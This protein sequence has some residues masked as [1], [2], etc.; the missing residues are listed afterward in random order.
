MIYLDH[1][2]TSWPK[3]PAVVAAVTTALQ[4]AGNP[5][6]GGHRLAMAGA[7]YVYRA[8][9]A[10]AELLA[11]PDPLRIV[12]TAGATAALNLALKGVLKPGD[13]VVFSGLEHN[14]VWRPLKK[15][16]AQGVHLTMVTPSPDGS[17]PPDAVANVISPTT[18]LIVLTHASN[19]SGQLNDI[20]AIANVAHDHGALI[21]V[22]AAQTAGSVPINAPTMAIDLL[23]FAGHKGLQGP[24]GVGGLYIRPGLMLDTLI[25]GGTGSASASPSQPD[26]LP[27]RYESGTLNVPG[28][29]GLEAGIRHVLSTGVETIYRQEQTLMMRLIDGLQHITPVQIYGPA[30]AAPRAGVVSCNIDGYD[31][32]TV[33][34]LLEEQY[35]IATRAGLH[36]APLAHRMQGTLACGSLRLSLGASSTTNDVDSALAAITALAERRQA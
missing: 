33:A 2:A 12:F 7:E 35:G 21:L 11:I 9:E 3:P 1:A 23:A 4:T 19:V 8:R 18:K 26:V 29:A 14:A 22:D 31:C 13:H 25:E 20:A 30:N 24:Q 6:R 28:L 5:G 10:V 27:D 17:I 32:E 16:Q 34:A 15:L 36:C